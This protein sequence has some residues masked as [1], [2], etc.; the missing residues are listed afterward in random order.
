MSMVKNVSIVLVT[1]FI[2]ASVA[3]GIDR[4]IPRLRWVDPLG[5]HQGSYLD[6]CAERGPM[7]PPRVQ[8]LHLGEIPK[9]ALRAEVV[10]LVVNADLAPQI[11]DVLTTY[12]SDLQ[13][14]GYTVNSSTW[15]GGSPAD[16]KDYLDRLGSNLVGAVLVGDLP[17]PFYEL[18]VWDHEEF[19][20]DLYLMDLDGD[21]RDSDHDGLFDGHYNGSGD[22]APEIWVGRICASRLTWGGEVDLTRRYF[23]KAHNY[24]TGGLSVPDRALAYVDDDWAWYF[25]DCDLSLAYSD[26]TTVDAY[27]TTVA[28][29]YKSRLLQG[30]EFVHICAHSCCWAHTFMINGGYWGGGT[31]YNFEIH[32]LH[33]HGL[34]YNLFACSNARFTETDNLGNWY[35]FVEPYGLAAVGAAKTGSMLEFQDFYGPLGQG[36]CFGEAN[37]RWWVSQASGGYDDYEKAWYYAN[38]VLGDPT[39]HIHGGGS[40]AEVPGADILPD[41][42]G[43]PGN[44]QWVVYQVSSDT[45]S[46]GRPALCA[47]LNGN[48][49]ATWE[50]ARDVRSNIYSSTFDGSSWSAAEDVQVYEYW[51]VHPAMAIDSSGTVW[52]TWQSLREPG[53]NVMTSSN[54]GSGWS[55]PKTVTSRGAYDLEPSLATAGDGTLWCVWK[56]WYGVDAE[57]F[58]STYTGSNWTSPTAITSDAAEDTD[59]VL[60]VDRDGRLWLVWSTNRDGDWNLYWSTNSGSGWTAQLPIT[61]DVGEDANPAVAADGLGN[62]WVVW[63]TDRD[64]DMNVYASVNYGSGWSSPEPVTTHTS[65]DLAPAVVCDPTGGVWAAWMRDVAGTW[66]VYWSYNDGGKW[67]SPQ[68][69]QSDSYSQYDPAMTVDSDGN[70]WVAWATPRDGDWNVY[71]ASHPPFEGPVVVELVPD[72]TVVERG[73]TLG[74]WGTATNK[75]GEP[76]TVQYWAEVVLPNGKPYP[77]NPVVGPIT[78]TLG[79]DQSKRK[80]LNHKIPMSAPLGVYTYTGLV[81]FYPDDVWD[82]S[83]F[84]FEVVE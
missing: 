69:V 83:S 34:F 56:S 78:A 15:S 32:D 62:V 73:G 9:G 47:D 16:L 79:P 52:V 8:P 24:R 29:D 51:D 33:P 57:I 43:G 72:A 66:A 64:G 13:A 50:S 26:V 81:G 30:Y 37:R 10:A 19:P 7:A 21:W 54:T 35:I 70:V 25:G 46:D 59:P 20:C 27:N 14:E 45:D 68:R 60:A 3:Y 40:A 4:D 36:Y 41:G 71:A 42:S 1:V 58:S 23:T 67:S 84:Q 11:Q 77:G 76:Q 12:V 65:D 17:V 53:F 80:H 5:R 55:S 82:D 22:V 63:Q 44:T 39:L 49:W 61:A 6:Y 75:I 48:V 31:V 18:D 74:Y 28:T 2:T 38:L